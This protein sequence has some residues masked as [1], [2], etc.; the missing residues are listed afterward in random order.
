MTDTNC[1]H[2]HGCL[3]CEKHRLESITEEAVQSIRNAIPEEARDTVKGDEPW[4]YEPGV[5]GEIASAVHDAV[6]KAARFPDLSGGT[7]Y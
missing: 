3:Q 6:L 4:N 7:L 2:G 1:T 5:G